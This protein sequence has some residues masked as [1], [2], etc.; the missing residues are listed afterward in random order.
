MALWLL[1]LNDDYGG[2]GARTNTLRP[3]RALFHLLTLGLAE[4]LLLL[5]NFS[6]VTVDTCD[7]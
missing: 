3:P 4:A 5:T 7:W 2:G 6:D 1:P